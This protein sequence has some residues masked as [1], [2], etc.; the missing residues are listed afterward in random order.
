MTTNLTALYGLGGGGSGKW[1][2]QTFTTSGVWQRPAGVEVAKVLL[3]G[4]G[5]SGA[6]SRILNG[7]NGG[8]SSFGNVLIARGGGRGLNFRF[9]R[10]NPNPETSGYPG[11]IGTGYPSYMSYDSS[12]TGGVVYYSSYGLFNSIKNTVP[13]GI[14][15]IS[16]AFGSTGGGGG[17][18]GDGG[19]VVGFGSGGTGNFGGG[20][21]A[22]YGNGGNGGPNV[23]SAGVFG[24][25]GGGSGSAGGGGGGEIIYR[26]IPVSTDMVVAIGSGGSSVSGNIREETTYTSGAGG[27]GLCIV[28]WQE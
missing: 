26:D 21:G 12:G 6:A 5:G 10:Y 25:G 8:N 11:G 16:S 13:S 7:F 2:S 9:N 20:G 27:N 22:S 14:I 3:V 4:G 17:T 19:N 28:F 18:T 23:G 1:K 15:G 24:G